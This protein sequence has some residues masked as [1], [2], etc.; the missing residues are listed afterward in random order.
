MEICTW[1][2]YSSC[3]YS[4]AHI[5]IHWDTVHCAR[6]WKVTPWWWLWWLA[7]THRSKENYCAVVGNNKKLTLSCVDFG[8]CQS[9]LN[10]LLKWIS[11]PPLSLWS[12]LLAYLRYKALVGHVACMWCFRNH[13][14][15]KSQKLNGRKNS[16]EIVVHNSMDKI[17]W[18]T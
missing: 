13:M 10:A 6:Q 17:I 18:E 9:N 15:C 5:A 3:C 14:L 1:I 4:N 12:Q 2:V 8:Q 16:T 11:P 7:K